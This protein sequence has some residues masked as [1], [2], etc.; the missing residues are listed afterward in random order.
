MLPSGTPDR[1]L[2]TWAQVEAASRCPS[3]FV[4]PAESENVS[5]SLIQFQTA[6]RT[7]PLKNWLSKSVRSA[8][9]IQRWGCEDTF[10]L[11]SVLKGNSFPFALY[12]VFPVSRLTNGCA[13]L[14]FLNGANEMHNSASQ[15]TAVP[16][17]QV[18][19]EDRSSLNSLPYHFAPSS[20]RH[21]P[22][23]R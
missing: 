11:R 1:K 22:Q 20:R 8:V 4:P 2:C 19:A 6:A 10:Q 9:F 21:D 17:L 16:P 13:D 7:R 12:P 5:F 23:P 18:P 15:A 14:C 3:D